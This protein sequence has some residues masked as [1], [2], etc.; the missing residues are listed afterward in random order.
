MLGIFC[1]LKF[2]ALLRLRLQRP[3]R[4]CGT[5]REESGTAGRCAAADTLEASAVA[6]H[7]PQITLRTRVRLIAPL[8]LRRLT[9]RELPGDAVNSGGSRTVLDN[10]ILLDVEPNTAAADSQ[11][12]PHY[13]EGSLGNNR[14]APQRT[15]RRVGDDPKRM[16]SPHLVIDASNAGSSMPPYPDRWMVAFVKTAI[17]SKPLTG[18][19]MQL[20][21]TVHDFTSKEDG[22]KTTYS[23]NLKTPPK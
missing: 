1:R 6:D 18:A 7:G 8:Y 12:L 2:W 14:L 22:I 21:K 4:R 11:T 13:L 3:D 17:R 23:V 15:L 9:E 10:G 16:K 5:R 20:K 19:D